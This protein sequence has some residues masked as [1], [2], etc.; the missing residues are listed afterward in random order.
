MGLTLLYV[1]DVALVSSKSRHVCVNIAPFTSCMHT[2]LLLS[3][4]AV[5]LLGA[6]AA[7]VE[8]IAER[9]R[10]VVWR[11]F[12]AVNENLANCDVCKKAVLCCGNTTN[13]YKHMKKHEKENSELQKT[14]RE[15]EG[16]P[17]DRP[18]NSHRVRGHWQS[19]FREA[20]IIQVAYIVVYCIIVSEQK[21]LCSEREKLSFLII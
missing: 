16:N 13:F 3:C 8:S 18:S 6:E 9:K 10:S 5:L 20:K 1:Q 15:E 12:M 2:V 21:P 11:C 19:P 4:F 17:S 14:W 7:V